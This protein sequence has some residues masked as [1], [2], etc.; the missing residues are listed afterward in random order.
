MCPEE[1]K[2]K[3]SFDDLQLMKWFI[4]LDIIDEYNIHS[5]FK[6]KFDNIGE[7]YR[8]SDF[9]KIVNIIENEYNGINQMPTT[10]EYNDAKKWCN[11]LNK[12]YSVKI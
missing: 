6:K 1:I 4:N 10:E 12:H 9:E 5:K 7:W 3:V 8:Y 11:N 2:N